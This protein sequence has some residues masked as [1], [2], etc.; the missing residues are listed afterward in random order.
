MNKHQKFLIQAVTRLFSPL[1]LNIKFSKVQL[2]K[3]IEAGTVS[4][5]VEVFTLGTRIVKNP[6]LIHRYIV[7]GKVTLDFWVIVYSM[8]PTFNRFEAIAV[9]KELHRLRD[10]HVSFYTHAMIDQLRTT[11]QDE[12]DD[13]DTLKAVGKECDHL[14]RHFDNNE[15]SIVN[16]DISR[17]PFKDKTVF[18]VGQSV[19]FTHAEIIEG[20]RALGGRGVKNMSNL[21]E[22]VLVLDIRSQSGIEYPD[23]ATLLEFQHV[24]DLFK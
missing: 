22:I 16:P 23:G 18:V 13:N 3:L 24:H 6:E 1:V 2:Q 20:I 8:I 15:M 9:A 7:D 19:D 5:L 4:S 11:A 17:N 21:V 10:P 12:F 14:D